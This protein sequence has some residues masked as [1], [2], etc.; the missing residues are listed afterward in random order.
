MSAEP[1]P[2]VGTPAGEPT[3]PQV[4]RY[5]RPGCHLCEDALAALERV[6]ARQPFTLQQVD[7]ESEEAL[8]RRYLER[9][10]VLTIDGREAF[11]LLVDDGALEAALKRARLRA[12][13]E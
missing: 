5:G 1:D 4:V 13:S 3:A 12:S 9:I 2:A 7:I 10:P 11:E 8:L 6:G